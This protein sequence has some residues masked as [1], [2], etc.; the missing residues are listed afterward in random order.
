MFLFIVF[1]KCRSL[2][3]QYRFIC[4]STPRYKFTH[5]NQYDRFLFFFL[6]LRTS[7]LFIVFFYT[8][9]F[10][11]FLFTQY[12]IVIGVLVTGSSSRI[13]LLL[14][15]KVKVNYILFSF[16]TKTPLCLWIL[17]NGLGSE[18]TTCPPPRA[19]KK[20]NTYCSSI[21]FLKQ[22]VSLFSWLLLFE[23]PRRAHSKYLTQNSGFHTTYIFSLVGQL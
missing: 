5:F 11:L 19:K 4:H 17:C 2:L 3:N 1:F 7:F 14:L 15:L 9:V 10:L 8:Q 6:S 13:L 23:D 16:Q 22:Y 21:V 18:S 12:P 20:I